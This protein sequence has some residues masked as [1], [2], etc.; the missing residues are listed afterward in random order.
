MERVLVTGASGFIGS[1]IVSEGLDK[2]YEVWAGVRET[3]SRKYL[4]DKRICFAQL[5]LGNQEEL[6]RQLYDLKQQ[7]GGH[8]WDYVVHAAGATKC[9]DINGFYRTN[10]EG[11]RNLVSGLIQCGMV[12]KRFVF[13]SSLSIFGAVR[14]QA[15]KQPAQGYGKGATIGEKESIYKPI[16]LTDTPQPNTAYGKSKLAAEEILRTLDSKAFPYVILR[17]TGV[18][19]PRE[20]DYFVMAQ[21]IMGHTDFAVGYHPQ[22]ITFIYMLDVVQAIY[23]S[24]TAE[25]AVGNAYFLS[26]GNIY[27][28]RRFSDLLQKEL[29]DPWV[30]HL[31]APVWLLRIICWFGTRWMKITKKLIVLNN[32]KFNIL[33]QRNWRCDI[34]PA[35][36]DLGFEPQWTLEAG[37]HEAVKWYR[38]NGWL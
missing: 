11:T 15:V 33:S 1:Y 4:Q 9:L 25:A 26:D 29:G 38:E 21:S 2:G 24:L 31:K 37:V 18:Y 17:P 16:K 34:E 3:S 23:K 22:E 28:S 13:V 35:R 10:T 12:P 7:L 20:K 30:L 5:T 32:D 19:G 6:R 8:G 36:K 14:E 27:S